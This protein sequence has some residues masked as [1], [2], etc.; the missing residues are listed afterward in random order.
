MAAQCTL[1]RNLSRQRRGRTTIHM[2]SK[3]SASLRLIRNGLVETVQYKTK[4]TA[5]QQKPV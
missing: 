3:L 2:K 5:K 1:L 4:G